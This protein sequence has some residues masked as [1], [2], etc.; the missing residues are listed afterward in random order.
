MKRRLL[1]FLTLATV[2]AGVLF[3][4]PATAA[5]PLDLTTS[6]LPINLETTPGKSVSTELRVK[7]S[8]GQPARLKVTLL[9]FAAYGEEGKPRLMDRQPEDTHF[10]WVKF[11]KPIF[12]AP[13]DVWQ[14]V[15]MTINVPKT[16]AAFGYYYAVMFSRAGDENVPEGQNTSYV[17][18][19]ATMVLLNVDVPGAKRSL[20]LESFGTR[21]RVVE[22]LPSTFKVKF[23][24][25]GNVHLVP[26]GNVFIMR[27]KKQV[28]YILLN[29][30]KGNILPDSKRV[31]TT[32]WIDGFPKFLPRTDNGRAVVQ[33]N[34]DPV[35]NV[36][37][38]L[39]NG[40]NP[41]SQIRFGKYT[42][43]LFAVYDDGQRDVPIESEVTFWV[44]PWRALL[45]ML[46][47]VLLI[48][49]GAWSVSRGALKGVRR[50]RR[51]GKR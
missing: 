39:N 50:M 5:G 13:N 46:L 7:Q 21:H 6:P 32:E 28:G 11:D 48:T 22:F 18:G 34:G 10:D 33:K 25:D 4:F 36:D 14:T 41:L 1:S 37:W 47:I 23:Q 19:S 9:K 40:K 3:P 15:K 45:V 38:N 49:F 8:T 12:T 26:K 27:G 29:E 17:G 35:Y 51:K 43:K 44:I 24:N 20:K 16:G 31:Y 30:E 2:L 42:A